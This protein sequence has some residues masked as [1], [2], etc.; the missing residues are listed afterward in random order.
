MVKLS[1]KIKFVNF[2]DIC[3]SCSGMIDSIFFLLFPTKA[4]R[5]PFN[6]SGVEVLTRVS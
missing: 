5:G 2:V 6:K 3:G 1:C 4:Q